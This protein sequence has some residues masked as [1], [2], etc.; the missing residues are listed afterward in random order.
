[1]EDFFMKNLIMYLIMFLSCTNLLHA[2]VSFESNG[3]QLDRIVGR[4]VALGDFN[5]DGH[6]DAFISLENRFRVYWG[7]GRGQFTNSNQN[8]TTP[9]KVFNSPIADDIDQDGHLDIVIGKRIW[10]NDGSGQ[11]TAK[12]LT[13]Q[14]LDSV[15]LADLNGDGSLDVFAV[16]NINASRVF[17]NDGAGNFTDSGQSL[18]DGTIGTGQITEIALGD[19]NN[20]GSIDAITTGWRW[21]GSTECPNQIWI[22]DGTGHFALSEQQ[23]EEGNSHVHGSNLLDLNSDGW[24]DLIL[25]IQDGSRCGRIYLNDKTGNFIGSSNISSRCGEDVELADFNGDGILELFIAQSQQP[26]RVWLSDGQGNLT[27]SGA[28]LGGSHCY[29]DTAVGDFNND[30]KP[31]VFAIGFIWGTGG[32]AR[33]EVWLNTTPLQDPNGSVENQTTG[34][35]FSAIQYAIHYAQPGD[36]IVME[37]G[38][39][40]ENIT[41][42]IDVTLQ[43]LDPDDPYYIGG[44]IIQ[45]NSDE[46]VVILNYNTESCTLAGLTLRAGL[47]GIGGTATD[48]TI[49]NCRIIDNVIHGLELADASCPLLESCLVTANGQTG[50]TMLRGPGRLSEHCAPIIDKCVIVDNGNAGI[51]GGE[52]AIVDSIIMDN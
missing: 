43:S 26:S 48:A 17:F 52:P 5:E 3:Q 37:P 21:N 32:A 9:F 40:T 44:T 2:Q 23:I 30:K 11:F 24:L 49:R 7:D 46:P 45:G 50:I 20:D 34:D 29:W 12:T 31:D 51:V 38:I 35:R 22:N 27:D 1:M 14:D 16:V 15:K 4:G 41:L 6:L 10:L 28:R 42:D 39:Y 18:G 25:A 47:V 36:K 13:S 19:I 8:L 33:M